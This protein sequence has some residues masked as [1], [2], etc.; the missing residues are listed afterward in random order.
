MEFQPYKIVEKVLDVPLRNPN[1]SGFLQGAY[2]TVVDSKA[3]EHA[4]IYTPNLDSLHDAPLVRINSACFTGD[5]FGDRRC[6]C[7]EQLFAAMDK[8]ANDPGLIVYNFHHEGRGL[9]FTGKLLTYKHMEE[10]DI[11]TFQAMIRQAGSS[12]L[13]TYNSA[14]TILKDLG[15][16][17][18]RLMSNNP[19]KKEVLEK[20][21]IEVLEVVPLVV[22]RPEIRK[23]L[24]TKI[25][26][27]GHTITFDTDNK[28]VAK[29]TIA[30]K[31]GL[32]VLGAKGTLGKA[33]SD[34]A[35]GRNT[36]MNIHLLDKTPEPLSFIKECDLS[37][38]HSITIALNNIDFTES[39]HWRILVATGIYNGI[40][41]TTN[42]SEISSTLQVNLMGVSQFVIGS[43]E[44]L[45]EANKTGRIVVVSSAA[46]SV[47]SRDIG[48]GISKAGLTGLVRSVS[49]QCARDGISIIGVAPGVFDSTMSRQNQSAERRDDAIKANHLG[50]N[51]NLE[52]VVASTSF[53]VFEAPDAMTG[54][55]INPN[56]GQVLGVDLE[57]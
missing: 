33:F 57:L 25:H 37:S 18:L 21:G 56:G 39:E 19:K 45:K 48:Y 26:G 17:R 8:I 42:W 5:I 53:A 38:P 54:T 36:P 34:A 6:D 30:Q 41:P 13:R 23:Y 22:D 3:A 12:D 29:P 14:I 2:K 40:A 7:T 10:E 27:Q 35:I 1:Y 31:N 4:I 55:F 51:L 16:N 52:E 47:G 9:G 28:D 32:I 49:K 43:A 50:R 15:I 44:K 24:M 46:A 11:S 20:A